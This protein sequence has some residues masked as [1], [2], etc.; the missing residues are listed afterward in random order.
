MYDEYQY[1][2][3]NDSKLELL[4]LVKSMQKGKTYFLI[5]T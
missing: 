2:Y 5:Y 4:K 3:K 1:A